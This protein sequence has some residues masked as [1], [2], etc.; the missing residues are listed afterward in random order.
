VVCSTERQVAPVYDVRWLWVESQRRMVAPLQ[1]TAVVCGPATQ[2]K[3]VE[4]PGHGQMVSRVSSQESG[5]RY[6]RPPR[7]EPRTLIGDRSSSERNQV[8][9]ACWPEYFWFRVGG[10]CLNFQGERCSDTSSLE[11]LPFYSSF[12]LHHVSPTR[13]EKWTQ[14]RNGALLPGIMRRKCRNNRM[15]ALTVTS[16]P[17]LHQSI[18]TYKAG[19]CVSLT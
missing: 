7:F 4:C 1:R 6:G 17:L 13:G 3:L 8:L 9:L 18:Q 12:E 2:W 16:I 5:V 11:R 14:I 15:L 10:A 19:G